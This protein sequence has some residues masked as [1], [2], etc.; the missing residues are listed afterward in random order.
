[1][2]ASNATLGNK[3]LAM[4]LLKLYHKAKFVNLYINKIFHAFFA[5]QITNI[6]H[7]SIKNANKN[8]I[9]NYLTKYKAGVK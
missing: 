4:H 1:M 6:N 2:Q 3:L 8:Y 9:I 7:S 5:M